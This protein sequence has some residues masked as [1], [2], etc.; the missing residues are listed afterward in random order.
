MMQAQKE[1]LILLSISFA[2]HEQRSGLGLLCVAC[3]VC[4]V[5]PSCMHVCFVA[6]S[7]STRA[8]A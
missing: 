6:Q 5:C 8:Q 4:N 7:L 3:F 2:L 1:H